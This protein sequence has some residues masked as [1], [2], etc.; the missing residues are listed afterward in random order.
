[1]DDRSD[2]DLLRDYA[3]HGQENAFSAIVARHLAMVYHSALRQTRDPETA[4]DITQTVFTLLAR[5]A[6]RLSSRTVLAGWLVKTT[7]FVSAHA[8]ADPGPPSAPR[9]GGCADDERQRRPE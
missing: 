3:R 1:M 2:G 4:K 7:S 8:P 6:R 9:G 5:K